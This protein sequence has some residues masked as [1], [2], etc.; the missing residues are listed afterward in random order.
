MT[1]GNRRSLHEG[2]ARTTRLDPDQSEQLDLGVITS[3]LPELSCT[4]PGHKAAGMTLD[5]QL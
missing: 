5:I 1:L 3:G 4:L 2:G